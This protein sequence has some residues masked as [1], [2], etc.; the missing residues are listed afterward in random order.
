[1]RRDL[2]LVEDD[3]RHRIDAGGEQRSGNLPRT[4]PQLLWILHYRYCV[5]IDDAIDAVVLRL[6]LYPIADGPEIVSE[7]QIAGGLHA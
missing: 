3:T 4:G 1:M 6:Q 5:Q 2:A 7:V